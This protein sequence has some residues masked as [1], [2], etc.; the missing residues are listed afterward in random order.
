MRAGIVNRV[1][2]GNNARAKT[3]G[4][5]MR[6]DTRRFLMAVGAALVVGGLGATRY[7]V[8]TLDQ[9]SETYGWLD[10]HW[11]TGPRLYA[12]GWIFMTIGAALLGCAWVRPQGGD[13]GAGDP[14]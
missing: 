8:Q 12:S 2:R 7:V 6:G 1:A 11:L 9:P 13:A 3:G 5:S 14:D 10:W 4:A